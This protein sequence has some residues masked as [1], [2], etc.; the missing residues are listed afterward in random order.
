MLHWHAC[1]SCATGAAHETAA[2]HLAW[3]ALV[4]PH[5]SLSRGIQQ[6]HIAAI[7]LQTLIIPATATPAMMP[8]RSGAEY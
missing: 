2:R 8:L 6:A 7:H 5:S 4:Y 1:K 3:L